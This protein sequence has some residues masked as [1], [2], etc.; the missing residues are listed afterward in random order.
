MDQRL[1][2]FRLMFPAGLAIAGLGLSLFFVPACDGTA[3]QGKG[4][5]ETAMTS[6]ANR[7]M[8]PLDAARP[9]KTETAIF[10]LG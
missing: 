1:T 7:T 6:P 3:P 9:A 8:P 5:K 4:G 2:I 10:A